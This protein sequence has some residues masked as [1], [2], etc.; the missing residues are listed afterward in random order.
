M[1]PSPIDAVSAIP[2]LLAHILGYLSLDDISAARRTCRQWSTAR[3]Q[4]RCAPA[5]I[6]RVVRRAIGCLDYDDPDGFH[7]ALELVGS[8]VAAHLV[9]HGPNTKSGLFDEACVRGRLGIAQRLTDRFA[10]T[11]ADVR[12]YDNCTLRR[13]CANGHLAVAQWLVDH[14]GF[15]TGARGEIGLALRATCKNGHLETAQ[16]LADHFLLTAADVRRCGNNNLWW[17]F[18]ECNPAIT[19][20]LVD[21]FELAAIDICDGRVDYALRWAFS[22]GHNEKVRWLADSFGL[23]FGD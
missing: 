14:F 10:L 3:I 1:E 21:R 13:A 23:I 5:D 18:K 22:A 16:W 4:V 9:S 19:Q 15:T 11:A 7:D 17:I 6:A 8:V 20:W 2:E 12:A